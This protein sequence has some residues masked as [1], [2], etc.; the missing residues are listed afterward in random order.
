MLVLVKSHLHS[1]KVDI[2]SSYEILCIN[3]PVAS[4]N[5]ILVTCYRPPDC[6]YAFIKD[7]HSVLVDLNS[8]FLVQNSFSAGTLIFPI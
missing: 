7:L 6:D 8:R 3:L 2:N 4:G 1:Y 5:H